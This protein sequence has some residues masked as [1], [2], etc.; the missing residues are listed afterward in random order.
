MEY[1]AA[2][3][4]LRNLLAVAAKLRRLADDTLHHE[5][6]NLYLAAAAVLE[7]RAERMASHLPDGPHDR[8]Q[9]ADL[10]RPVN[11]LV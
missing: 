2:S 9:D 8:P 6:K 1:F 4:D 3:R 10:H 11:L 7:A 5:D